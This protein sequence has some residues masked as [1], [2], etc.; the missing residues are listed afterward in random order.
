MMA[1]ASSRIVS[2]LTWTTAQ[3]LCEI[4]DPFV[5]RQSCAPASF[6]SILPLLPLA[7]PRN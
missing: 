3:W 1:L 2:H 5:R 4:N 6:G 7:G